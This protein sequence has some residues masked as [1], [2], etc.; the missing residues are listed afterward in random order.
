LGLEMKIPTTLKR[1]ARVV[2]K[3]KSLDINVISSDEL[4]YLVSQQCGFYPETVIRY[5]KFLELNGH[6]KSKNGNWEIVKK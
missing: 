5:M 2:K 4:Y 6:I 1:L 3:L